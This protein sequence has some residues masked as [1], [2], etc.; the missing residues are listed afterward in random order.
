MQLRP[1]CAGSI[2][3]ST[4]VSPA[5]FIPLAED[6]GL[7]VPIGEWVLRSA[8]ERH[9]AWR[10][11]GGAALRMM[12]ATFRRASS[13][14]R[15]SSPWSA[16]CSPRP[17]CRPSAYLEL[18]ESMLMDNTDRAIARLEQLRALGIA[19]AI[20]DF[21][22]GYSSLAY[23][24]RFPIDELKIDRLFVRGIIRN[25]RDAA[26][27]AAIISLGHS[28]GLRVVAEGVETLGHL[29][30][31]QS[32]GCDLAKASTSAARCR[33]RLSSRTSARAPITC[34][35]VEQLLAFQWGRSIGVGLD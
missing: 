27:V 2:P 29:K 8:C 17:R 13:A 5:D 18:T 14:T 35:F 34:A 26:L 20:D 23:L 33:G 22:T 19:L 15:V 3:T 10:E 24:E 30:V 9:R 6:T 11:A 12:G 32:E 21:A 7:I 16:A 25:T 28:L 1:C 31:L 4:W